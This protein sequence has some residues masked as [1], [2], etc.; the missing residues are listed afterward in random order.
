MSEPVLPPARREASDMEPRVVLILGGATLAM[1]GFA[2]LAVL[3]IFPGTLKDHSL[4]GPLPVFADPQ[5]QT[6][7]PRDMAAFRAEEAKALDGYGWVDRVHG[8]VHVPIRAAM[9]R[10]A[11]DGIPGWPAGGAPR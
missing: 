11:A 5:L 3:W 6:S 10:L 2:L 8:V 7:P 1:L 4:G 9:A